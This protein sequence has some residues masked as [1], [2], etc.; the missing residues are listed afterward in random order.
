MTAAAQTRHRIQAPN[1]TPRSIRVIA[2][3]ASSEA[4]LA[5]LAR[6]P[7]RHAAFLTAAA[8]IDG[9]LRDLAGRRRDLTD[10][11]RAADLVVMVATPG[12]HAEAASVIGQACS[13][14]RVT[15]TALVVGAGG[16]P[17]EMVSRTLAQ[18]RPWALML[19][20]AGPEDYVADMLVALRA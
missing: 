20:I 17:D 18:V 16:A 11:I 3:D 10:E 2:L 6:R 19:V 8:N 14:A 7:W 15:T 9:Q 5:R 13:L 1:S 4:L 12:G